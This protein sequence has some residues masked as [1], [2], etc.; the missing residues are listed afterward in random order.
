V[1]EDR[2]EVGDGAAVG[3]YEPARAARVWSGSI[4]DLGIAG[5]LDLERVW[6]QRYDPVW[7]L[8]WPGR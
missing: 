5:L 2:C 6:S 1:R 8:G 3:A 7:A 4:T